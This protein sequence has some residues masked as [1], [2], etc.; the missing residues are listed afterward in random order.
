MKIAKEMIKRTMTPTIA[1]IEGYL[2]VL[3]GTV[4]FLALKITTKLNINGTIIY[5]NNISIFI[6]FTPTAH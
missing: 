2:N 1:K 5:I 4:L 3:F 6:S